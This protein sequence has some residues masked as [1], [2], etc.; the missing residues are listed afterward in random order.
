MPLKE[1][2]R[3]FIKANL[4]TFDDAQA[5]RDDDNIF[6]LGFVESSFSMELF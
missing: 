2:V 3:K 6:K 5:L 1:K 4:L